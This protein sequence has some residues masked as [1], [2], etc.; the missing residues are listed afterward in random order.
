MQNKNIFYQLRFETMLSLSP[1]D[2]YQRQILTLPLSRDWSAIPF[3]TK[4]RESIVQ[5]TNDSEVK[6]II[7]DSHSVR[8]K[9]FLDKI[10]NEL[11]KVFKIVNYIPGIDVK[12]NIEKHLCNGVMIGTNT[13]IS[14]LENIFKEILITARYF[15][16]DNSD[17]L[18]TSIGNFIFTIKKLFNEHSFIFNPTMVS[19]RNNVFKNQSLSAIKNVVNN[20]RSDMVAY[21]FF[22]KQYKY[23]NVQ[24]YKWVKP[25]LDFFIVLLADYESTKLKN[26]VNAQIVEQITPNSSTKYIYIKNG[27]K[28]QVNYHVQ[29]AFFD[30]TLLTLPSWK[31]RSFGLGFEAFKKAN[32][33]MEDLNSPE[34]QTNLENFMVE[35]KNILVARESLKQ[36]FNN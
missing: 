9:M 35:F 18:L 7:G 14:N 1:L 8:V 17:E 24:Q 12:K 25:Y 5:I 15:E 13:F 6:T 10:H 34:G 33:R 30:E 16:F 11:D 4:L 27:L 2:F 3:T 28:H 21:C 26:S 36:A 22:I 19:V 23:D 20:E 31:K 32:I 29:A